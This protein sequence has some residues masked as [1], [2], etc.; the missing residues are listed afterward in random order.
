MRLKAIASPGDR[1][2]SSRWR[3]AQPGNERRLARLRCGSVL[4]AVRLRRR[5][6]SA[7]L[8]GAYLLEDRAATRSFSST[9]QPEVPGSA[10]ERREP[11]T[12]GSKGNP[13]QAAAQGPSVR[14]RADVG[15]G[16]AAGPCAENGDSVAQPEPWPV[17]GPL[18]TD[19]R[20]CGQIGRNPLVIQ[21]DLATDREAGIVRSPC[22]DG[23]M[24]GCCPVPW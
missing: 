14:A 23:V 4:E 12:A 1:R 7:A 18:A 2:G 21:G 3:S 24:R 9:G 17:V 22:L 15:G 5:V 11:T 20:I 10:S 19:V 8:D 13:S 16:S 6:L